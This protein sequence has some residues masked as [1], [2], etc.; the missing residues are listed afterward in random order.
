MSDADTH[1]FNQLPHTGAW[2][3]LGAYEGHETVRFTKSETTII[4]D[5]VTAGVEKDTPWGIHYNIILSNYWRV[6][7][8]SLTSYTDVSLD[9]TVSEDGIWTVNGTTAPELADCQD[10]DLEVS[11]VTNTIPIHRLSMQVGQ[12]GESSALYIRKD[13]TIERLDQTYKRLPDKKG[14]LVFDYSSPQFNY[15]DSLRF[16]SDG[17]VLEYPSIATRL[18]VADS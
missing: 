6:Q 5:G 12:Q 18:T 9:I 15:R 16:A 13:L 17:L 11:A 4:L 1:A 8:V 10:V 7:R 2:R 14:A 3:L